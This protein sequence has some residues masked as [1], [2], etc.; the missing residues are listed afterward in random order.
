MAFEV[1]EVIMKNVL[2]RRL[3]PGAVA[4][5][6]LALALLLPG[7]IGA[8]SA[9]AASGTIGPSILGLGWHTDP[10]APCH[11]DEV[12][13]VFDVC[14]CTVQ[15]VGAKRDSVGPIVV[16][17]RV[18]PDVVCVRCVPDTA[19]IDLGALAA[20]MHSFNVRVDIEYAAP[21]DTSWPASPVFDQA[22]FAVGP[23]CPPPPGLVPYLESVVIENGSPCLTCPAILCPGDSVDVRLRG[24]FNDSCHH[25]VG[26]SLVPNPSASPLPLPPIIRLSYGDVSPCTL[27]SLLPVPWEAHVRL[28]GQPYS[29]GLVLPLTVEAEQLNLCTPDSVGTFLGAANFPFV[30]AESCSTTPP[31]LPACLNVRWVGDGPASGGCTETYAYGRTSRLGFAVG[32]TSPIAG[33]Q[34]RLTLSDASLAITNVATPLR[35][36]QVSWTRTPEGD[37]RFIAFNHVP[38]HPIGGTP[39]GVPEILLTVDVAPVVRHPL[40]ARVVLLAQDLL[41]SDV[42]GNAILPCPQITLDIPGPS[43]AILCLAAECDANLDGQSDVR[44]LV[45]MVGCMQLT[46]PLACTVPFDR[47]DCDSDSDFDF[48]D[49]FCCV[50]HML[51]GDGDGDPPPDSLSREAPEIAARFDLPR[52]A[53]DGTIE[54]PLVL[55]GLAAAGVAAARLDLA[56]P[57][58]RYEVVGVSFPGLPSPWWTLHESAP[59][60]VRVALIDLSGTGPVT[61]LPTDAPST[62]SG[63]IVLRLRLKA[64]ATEGGEVAV[65]THDFAAGDGMILVTPNAGARL[66]MGAVGRVALSA[67]RPNPFVAVTSLTLTLP[68]AGPVDVGVFDVAGRRVATLL[69]ESNAA[70]GVH[71]L[72]WNGAEAGGARAARGVYF[73]RVVGARG[74]T[75]RKILFLPGSAR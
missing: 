69:H 58:A 19:G 16:Q 72:A 9:H 59:G 20:G 7:S 48:D 62:L 24:R 64:G 40:P 71:L 28:P 4:A 34:G 6:A 60:R 65:A 43:G 30:V 53:A 50:R 5:S 31:P 10:F 35:E 25:L 56:Y 75:S 67:A 51:G 49:L 37:V 54:V 39:G 29:G 1:R 15:L 11:G 42:E 66:A 38:G 21:P 74:D 18:D 46:Q 23:D 45:L 12:R 61:A 55:D 26:V 73:V 13:L 36:W 70:A 22:V 44:D 57:D 47:L 33:V 3:R 14:E 8:G 52:P 68:V 27:C 63:S 2:P 41:A 32:S 17:L